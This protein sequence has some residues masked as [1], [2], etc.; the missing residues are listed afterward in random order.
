MTSTIFL[1]SDAPAPDQ[2]EV[3]VFGPGTGECIV[4]HTG[5]NRWM[6]VDSCMER[7]QPAALRYLASVGVPTTCIEHVVV[8]HWHNDHIRGIAAVFESAVNAEVH[9]SAALCSDEFKKLVAAGRTP[10]ADMGTTELDRLLVARRARNEGA[11]RESIGTAWVAERTLISRTEIAETLALSPSSAT[12]TLALHEI[13]E[14][15]PKPGPKRNI[16]AQRANSVAVVLL[17]H[18][19]PPRGPIVLLGSDLEVTR[20]SNTGW[21]AVA[22]AASKL[23]LGQSAVYKVAHHG[24]PTGYD[25][26]IWRS[27]V[28]ANAHCVVTPFQA[29]RLPSDDDR[30]RLRNHSPHVYLTAPEVGSRPRRRELE[31]VIRAAAHSRRTIGSRMGHVRLRIPPNAVAPNDIEVQLFGAAIRC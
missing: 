3:S 26:Q 21:H 25:A 11:R 7:G 10:H 5:H 6:V 13:A 9:C 22:L 28:S 1:P 18:C 8:S 23:G 19:H 24:S 4:V 31:S 16:V 14:L 20:A 2:V 15:L 27:L 29:S 17:V 30:E 12:Q